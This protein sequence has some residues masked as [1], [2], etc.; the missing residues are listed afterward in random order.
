MKYTQPSPKNHEKPVKL[1][2]ILQKYY[3]YYMC[4]ALVT[5]V[6]CRLARIA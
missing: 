5:Y 6:Y 1:K 3:M 4:F 2:N